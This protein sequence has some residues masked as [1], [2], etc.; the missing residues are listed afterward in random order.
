MNAT[1][2]FAQYLVN[3]TYDNLPAE[4]VEYGSFGSLRDE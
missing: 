2:L 4:A 1:Q 3:S